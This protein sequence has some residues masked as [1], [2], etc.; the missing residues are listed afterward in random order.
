LTITAWRI[1]KPK[2]AAVA[3][4]GEGARR[5]AGRWNCKG[6][7]V[8]YVADS[9]ALAALEMLVHLQARQ[10]LACYLVA[11]VRFAESLV[12]DLDRRRLPADWRSDP[13]P[14]ALQALGDRWVDERRSAVLRVPSAVIETE[15]NY[16]L[17]PA[18]RDFAKI[19]VGA[20]RP[21][22]FDVRLA[23]TD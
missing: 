13:A 10:V 3:F 4:T 15:N 1:F 16:L 11:P 14:A 21:C 19:R 22:R 18:H 17:N 2:F 8:V 12:R 6:T 20:A 23:R 9:L 7:A 5:Y